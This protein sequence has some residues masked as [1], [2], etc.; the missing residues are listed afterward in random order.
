MNPID[1]LRQN[2]L[3]PMVLCFALGCIA[4]LLKSD[5]RLPESVYA[6]LSTYLLFAIGLKGGV[7][8]SNYSVMSIIH[9]VVATLILGFVIPVL[10]FSFC[11]YLGRMKIA[12]AAAIAAH[13]GSV[14][15][16]TFIASLVFLQSA[17]E[18]YEGYLPALVAI[19]EIPAIV[20]GLF[21][22]RSEM[23]KGKSA[24]AVLHEIVTGKSIVLLAGGMAVGWLTKEQGYESVK[25]FFVAPFQGVLCLFLLDMGLLAASKLR[26]LREVGVFL[27]LF[28]LSA[29]ILNG[30]LGVLLGHWS[31]LSTGGATVLGAMAASASYIAAPA[32]VRLALPQA[33]P[34]YYLTSA[35]GITFPFNLALGLPMYYSMA[36]I[37]AGWGW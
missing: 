18:D 36:Q 30:A 14:S 19:L 21:M 6:A 2:L 1:L 34:S 31:G 28:A 27:V 4:R 23:G 17:G 12:D 32:A 16:V 26:D 29:P 5:L 13:Y 11:R 9:P 35:I 7:A 8:L 22:A 24:G 25:P 37:V 10:A 20:V 33:N 3:S 15:A